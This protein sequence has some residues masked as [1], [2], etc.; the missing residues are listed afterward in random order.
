MHRGCCTPSALLIYW[1]CVSVPVHELAARKHGS[2]N[3]T[4]KENNGFNV[5]P[6][7]TV[8]VQSQRIFL[9]RASDELPSLRVCLS[10]CKCHRQSRNAKLLCFPGCRVSCSRTKADICI[11]RC[12]DVRHACGFGSVEPH[13]GRTTCFTL[14]ISFRRQICAT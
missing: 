12:A 9:E 14:R 8:T 3:Q 13:A 10:L 2:R 4:E 11:K 1:L 7:P 5:A 6:C